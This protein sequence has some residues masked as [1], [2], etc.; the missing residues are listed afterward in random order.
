MSTL[1]GHV[2]VVREL[3][4]TLMERFD[5]NISNIPNFRVKAWARASHYLEVIYPLLREH[6]YVS[7]LAPQSSFLNDFII[8]KR[9]RGMYRFSFLHFCSSFLMNVNNM[10]N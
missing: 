4:E 3:P 1:D 7:L 10:Y 8:D 2:T 9:W 6:G 5:Y